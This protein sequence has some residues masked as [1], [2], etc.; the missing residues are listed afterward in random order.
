[1]RAAQPSQSS[2]PSP[3]SMLRM[4]YWSQRLRSSRPCRRWRASGPRPPGRTGRPC[5]TRRRRGRARSRSGRPGSTRSA[6]RPP[7]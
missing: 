6:L 7:R 2:S 1:V 4:G 3:S 5:R